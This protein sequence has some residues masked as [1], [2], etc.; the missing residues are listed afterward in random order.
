MSQTL[1]HVKRETE[2][3][4]HEA[5]AACASLHFRLDSVS[6][7]GRDVVRRIRDFY[8][9]YSLILPESTTC[10]RSCAPGVSHPAYLPSPFRC[11]SMQIRR[12]Q[13]AAR[14]EG[15]APRSNRKKRL[16][17]CPARTS[18]THKTLSLTWR[19]VRPVVIH[20]RQCVSHRAR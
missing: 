14:I 19:I 11:R 8:R 9:S 16:S 4:R 10:H 17:S 6:E 1:L 5:T 2:R 12:V 7:S 18:R 20:F 3:S 15:G 13:G